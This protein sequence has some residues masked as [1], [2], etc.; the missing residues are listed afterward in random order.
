MNFPPTCIPPFLPPF[1]SQLDVFTSQILISI[2]SA[3]A[4]ALPPSRQLCSSQR[5]SISSAS[6]RLLFRLMRS[7]SNHFSL[8][9]RVIQAQTEGSQTSVHTWDQD[10]RGHV[11]THCPWDYVCLGVSTCVRVRYTH[12]TWSLACYYNDDNDNGNV[13]TLSLDTFLKTQLCHEKG[14]L[15]IL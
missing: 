9:L 14:I 7:C 10:S 6:L 3:E 13:I 2:T 1:P 5:R 12:K 8:G 4:L 15:N 11:S